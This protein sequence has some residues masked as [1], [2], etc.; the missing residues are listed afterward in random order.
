MM[1]AQHRL[2]SAHGGELR[3]EMEE[4]QVGHGARDTVSRNPGQ[5]KTGKSGNIRRTTG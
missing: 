1:P 3:V 4:S 5:K 2:E